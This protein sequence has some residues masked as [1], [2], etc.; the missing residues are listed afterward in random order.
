MSTTDDQTNKAPNTLDDTILYVVING[1]P[2]LEYD[3][4]KACARASAP[5]FR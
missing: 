2:I 4:K 1:E 3:R 5:I